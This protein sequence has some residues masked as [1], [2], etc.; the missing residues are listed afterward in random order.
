MLGRK[1][2]DDYFAHHCFK[3][4]ECQIGVKARKLVNT[5]KLTENYGSVHCLNYHVASHTSRSDNNMVIAILYI[6]L[7]KI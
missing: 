5:E 2:L 1:Y 4:S 6:T 3:S 7:F